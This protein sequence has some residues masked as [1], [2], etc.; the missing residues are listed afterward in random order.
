LTTVAVMLE[1]CH[2]K[3]WVRLEGCLTDA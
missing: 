2:I 1:L 3:R